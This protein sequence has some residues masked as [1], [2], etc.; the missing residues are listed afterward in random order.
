MNS[1]A[2]YPPV[3]SSAA[4]KSAMSWMTVYLAALKSVAV[5]PAALS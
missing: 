2:V 5:N 4:V 1:L 3:L